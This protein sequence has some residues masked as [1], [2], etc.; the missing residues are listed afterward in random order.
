MAGLIDPPTDF[1]PLSEWQRFAKDMRKLMR[2]DPVPAAEYLAMAEK[3]IAE[4]KAAG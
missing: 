1:A 3:K 2:T 4:L